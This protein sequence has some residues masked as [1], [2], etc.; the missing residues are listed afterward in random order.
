MNRT[1][2]ITVISV[3]AVSIV[4]TFFLLSLGGYEENPIAAKLIK[5]HPYVFVAFIFLMWGIMYLVFVYLPSKIVTIRR[6]SNLCLFALLIWLLID[7][8]H[9]L[10]LCIA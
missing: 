5:I 4:L 1:L 3:N 7:M 8:F 10:S 9:N 2:F 6:I